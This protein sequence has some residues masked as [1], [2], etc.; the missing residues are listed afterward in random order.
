MT[1]THHT[2]SCHRGAVRYEV[3][4]DR[5]KAAMQCNCS[6]C[7]RTGSLLQF[8]PANTFDGRSL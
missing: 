1:T 2:G 3:E 5:D 8:V 4:L 7:G 6:M